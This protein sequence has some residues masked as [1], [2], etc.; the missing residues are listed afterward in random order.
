MNKVKQLAVA[1][2]LVAAAGSASAALTNPYSGSPSSILFAIDDNVAG[3]ANKDH[4]FILDLGLN[5]A[6]FVNKTGGTTGTLTW[7][8]SSYAGFSGFS[9]DLA[10]SSRWSVVGGYALDTTDFHNFDPTGQWYSSQEAA[11]WGVESSSYTDTVQWGALVTGHKAN[12]ADFAR[13][14]YLAFNSEIASNSGK[15][16]NWFAKAAQ[17]LGGAT[18]VDKTLV[19]TNQSYYDKWF[20][21]LGTLV[22]GSTT[23]PNTIQ[24]ATYANG[25]NA[26]D[27]YWLTN[28][29]STDASAPNQ[30]TK[31]GSF[32]LNNNVLTWTSATPPAQVPVP[33]TVWLF[34]SGL[35]G[36]IGLKRRA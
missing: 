26:A 14:D 32:S 10:A 24:G 36:L 18:S 29:T 15:I 23:A 8:L 6:D 5:Y 31:L 4:T 19:Q 22:A 33:G 1:V 35:L 9:N 17:A 27:F 16:G 21:D 28:S 3:S 12:G 7:N 30:F 11:D 34:L 25:T 13:L 2:S 20:P